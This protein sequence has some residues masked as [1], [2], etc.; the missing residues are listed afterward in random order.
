MGIN[1]YQIFY[2]LGKGG[3]GKVYCVERIGTNHHFAMKVV[4]PSD[5]AAN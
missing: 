2:E 5:L 3:Q 1:K 4:P